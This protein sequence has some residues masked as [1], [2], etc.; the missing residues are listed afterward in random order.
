MHAATPNFAGGARHI[1]TMPEGQPP[2]LIAWYT[3]EPETIRQTAES[4]Y[5]DREKAY[6]TTKNSFICGRS[7]SACNLFSLDNI[8]IDCDA[9]TSRLTDTLY[10]WEC[11]KALAAL[12][13]LQKQCKMPACNVV[14]SGR[15]LH[16]WIPLD[17]MSA[18]CK[19]YYGLYAAEAAHTMS[20]A[21]KAIDSAF[22]VDTAAT[23]NASGLIRLPYTMNP[24][25]DRL[26]V[27][28]Q[29][30]TGRTSAD[31]LQEIFAMNVSTSGRRYERQHG[32]RTADSAQERKAYRPLIEKRKRFIRQLIEAAPKQDGRRQNLLFQF[33]N[34]EYC[35]NGEQ[36]ALQAVSMLNQCFT[37]PLAESELQKM[38][39][40]IT[41][42]GGLEFRNSTFLAFISA[43]AAEKQEYAA[44]Q[45]DREQ[46]RA[47][48]RSAKAER[49]AKI[50]ALRAKGLTF[51]QIAA[52][53]QVNKSTVSR[54]IKAAGKE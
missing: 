30:T 2:K 49:N 23:M 8:V 50:L 48:A 25:A 10:K 18:K 54:I 11:S 9:H 1:Y 31:E 35:V 13:E 6:F 44:M 41:Q 22:T 34:A 45:N 32:R 28:E 36:S 21:C 3:Q 16:I 19:W 51:D 43:D 20:D 12:E 38:H 53:T 24:K 14:R 7:R 5:F 15:G 37:S 42:R 4:L 26:A 17:S 29:R 33:C 47:Q 27:F 40:Y 39:K 52:E 46:Q